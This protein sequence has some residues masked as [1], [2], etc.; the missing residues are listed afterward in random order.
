MIGVYVK[1]ENIVI[2]LRSGFER[3]QF[4]VRATVPFN[5]T[6]GVFSIVCQTKSNAHLKSYSEMYMRVTEDDDQHEDCKRELYTPSVI[7]QTLTYL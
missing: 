3:S 2:E 4:N 7:N 5:M 1:R 6:F